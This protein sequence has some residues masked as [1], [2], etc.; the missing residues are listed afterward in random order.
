MKLPKI[1]TFYKLNQSY[2]KNDSNN[3][4][5]SPIEENLNN[6]IINSSNKLFFSKCYSTK[7]IP[8]ILSSLKLSH[9]TIKNNKENIFDNFEINKDDIDNNYKINSYRD[10]NLSEKYNKIQSIS[11]QMKNNMK[12]NINLVNKKIKIIK[13]CD[14]LF[15]NKNFNTNDNIDKNRNKMNI[16]IEK[17]I[18]DNINKKNEKDEDKT[19]LP[20][21]SKILKNKNI[22]SININ[23]LKFK[24]FINNRYEI[25]NELTKKKAIDYN[26][27]KNKGYHEHYI[28]F[29][30][31][32]LGKNSWK[33]NLLK[34]ILPKNI[35][36]ILK[37]R[38]LQKIAKIN[39]QLSQ[40][41][42]K[43]D[44]IKI[45]NKFNI[46]RNLSNSH[47]NS[48]SFFNSEIN[49]F[50][51]NYKNNNCKL[52]LF[53]RNENINK[54]NNKIHFNKLH[55]NISYNYNLNIPHKKNQN[56]CN[57]K[58]AL[59]KNISYDLMINVNSLFTMKN[60]N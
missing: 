46:F 26:L 44:K 52:I 2:E 54:D 39:S 48:Y 15:V 33:N 20:F 25:N 35:N 37:E 18:S 5:Q 7:F 21:S 6:N 16:L 23:G 34:N 10:L 60:Y 40:E 45:K 36:Y 47:D 9:N 55:K 19:I 12:I 41:K 28:F 56:N 49:H 27:D 38:E 30:N 57:K 29:N 3:K 24:D 13:S 51:N 58:N 17:E 31:S 8:K 53:K 11:P 32:F 43:N 14:N 22:N 50:Y 42:E 4:I 59:I 1:E